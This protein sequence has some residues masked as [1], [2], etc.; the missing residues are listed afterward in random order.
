VTYYQFPPKIKAGIFVI[1]GKTNKFVDVF[2]LGQKTLNFRPKYLWK[3]YNGLSISTNDMSNPMQ[4][5]KSATEFIVFG[6]DGMKT[7]ELLDETKLP[8]QSINYNANNTLAV[9]SQKKTM[10]DPATVY[11]YKVAP[12][13]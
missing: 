13:K 11:V 4:P 8:V 5:V 3:P 1:D 9:I 6:K 12:K 7:V 2:E 10:Q